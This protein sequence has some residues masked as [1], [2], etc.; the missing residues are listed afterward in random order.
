[1]TSHEIN[2]KKISRATPEQAKVLTQIAFTAKRHW[3]YPERWIEI[4]SP[5]LTISEEFIQEHPT[6]IVNVDG[7]SVG[8]YALSIQKDKASLEHL[9]VL[10]AYMGQGIGK[11]LF[12]HAIKQ[13]KKVRV[14]FLEI[15][16]DPHAQGFYEHMGAIKTGEKIGK[17]DDQPRVLPIL[18]IHLT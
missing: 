1:M 7:K 11:V 2:G 12:E 16:S 15:E 13:C 3:G 10:P 5:I 9:W 17:V 18:E 8:F 4:W 6:Y 14:P